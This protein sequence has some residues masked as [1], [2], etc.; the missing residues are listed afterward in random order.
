MLAGVL[1]LV[2][3]PLLMLVTARSEA[4]AFAETEQ[5]QREYTQR[6]LSASGRSRITLARPRR[7]SLALLQSVPTPRSLSYDSAHL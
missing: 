4:S 5:R 1:Q 2:A 6:L 3:L 7:G